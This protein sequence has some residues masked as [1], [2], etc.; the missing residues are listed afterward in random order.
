MKEFICKICKKEFKAK[1]SLSRHYTTHHYK[2]LQDI[3][4]KQLLEYQNTYEKTEIE[5]IIL[6]LGNTKQAK[7]EQSIRKFLSFAKNIEKHHKLIKNDIKIYDEIYS[8]WRKLHPNNV[9]SKEYGK[10][11]M[12]NDEALGKEFYEKFIVTKN[13]YYKHD[14]TLSPFSKVFVGYKNLTEKEKQIKIIGAT[15]T[16]R[17]DRTSNQVEYWTKKGYSKDEAVKKVSERQTTFSL[18]ICIENHG[19]IEGKKIFEQR[20]E[21]WMK[22]LDTPENQEKLKNGR[23]AGYA[24]QGKTGYSKISQEL[25]NEILK[26]IKY[27]NIYFGENGSNLNNEYMISFKQ[28]ASKQCAMLDFYIKDIN[29]CIEFDGDYWHGEARGNQESD[30]IREELIKENC[31]GIDILHVKERDYNKDKEKIIQECVEW[32]KK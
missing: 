7:K 6:F 31:I 30:R 12:G 3:N 22:S 27:D 10:K 14:G 5:N 17:T 2:K 32:I 8:P 19:E 9:T 15:Q 28:P 13:P 25:F 16:E 24:T 23:I 4:F 18:E 29:K 11:L 20:Q 21:K 1:S 26:H